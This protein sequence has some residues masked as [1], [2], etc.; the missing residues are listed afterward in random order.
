MGGEFAGDE[1]SDGGR[2]LGDAPAA[3]VGARMRAFRASRQ[4]LVSMAI[5]GA[6]PVHVNHGA[7]LRNSAHRRR[8]GTG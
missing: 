5:Q 3:G 2:G 7:Q 6:P 8:L 1:V 4:P